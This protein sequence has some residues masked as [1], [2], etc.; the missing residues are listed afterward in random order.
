MAIACSRWLSCLSNLPAFHKRLQRVQIEH[1]SWTYVLSKYDGKDALFYLD[2]P[3][4]KSTRKSGKY[5]HE[6]SLQDHEDIVRALLNIKG[7]AAMSVYNHEVYEPLAQSGWERIDWNVKCDAVGRIS[8]TN[9]KGEG[10]IANIGARTESLLL[11]PELATA[12]KKRCLM[13]AT[14]I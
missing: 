7:Q 2:P 13:Q 4:L 9:L 10:A 6:L 5:S 12:Q 11:S 1:S 14:L 8:S 3:Y